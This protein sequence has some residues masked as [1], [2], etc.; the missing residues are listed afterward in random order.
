MVIVTVIFNII[1]SFQK[2]STLFQAQKTYDIVD[3]LFL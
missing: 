2:K 1:F 3:A